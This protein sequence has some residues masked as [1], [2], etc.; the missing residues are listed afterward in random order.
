LFRKIQKSGAFGVRIL[1]ADN[2]KE[3]LI[4]VLR[5]KDVPKEVVAAGTE[6][7]SL[8]GLQ[9]GA[10]EYTVTYGEIPRD[11]KELAMQT[12]SMMAIMVELSGQIDVPEHHIAEG[13]TISALDRPADDPRRLISIHHSR[14]KPD[15]A[16]IA[17]QYKDYW[18]WIDDRD[19]K[20]KRTFAYLMILFSLT[21]TG[22]S[23]SLP[24]VTI[25]AG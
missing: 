16:F 22:G 18:F 19:F 5:S 6:L 9:R 4:L 8:L 2:E 12:R 7:A 13:R 25:P 20:S 17:V 14:S 24:L 11:D 10:H 23:E 3:A 1:N 15:D 21:E